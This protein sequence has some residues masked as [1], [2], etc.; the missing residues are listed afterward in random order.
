MVH[1][2]Q[3]YNYLL[4]LTSAI[5]SSALYINGVFEDTLREI[6]AAEFGFGSVSYAGAA[7]V[8]AYLV[9]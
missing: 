4:G 2:W 5:M 9:R 3:L 6:V 7:G 8:S 1:I